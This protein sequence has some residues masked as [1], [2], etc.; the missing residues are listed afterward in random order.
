MDNKVKYNCIETLKKPGSPVVIVSLA[1]EA[2]AVA[3]A[4]RDAGIVVT[5]FCD[6]EKRKS[7]KLFCGLE[8]IHTPA[9]PKHFPKARFIIAY[10]NI[11]DCVEQLSAMGYDEFYSSLELLENY[12]V[13]KH[14]HST[15]QSYMATKISVS[16]RSHELYFDDSK[17]YLRS[18]DIV[19][20]TKC[21]M[22]CESCNNLMQY[23]VAAKN[24]DHEILSAVEILNENVGDISEF[25]V[26]G[27]EPFMNKGWA[28]IVNGII[29]KDS[30]REVFVYTNGTI[31]PKDDQLKSIHGKKV[32]FYITDYGKLSRN[33]NKLTENLTKHGI[34]Y[35]RIP[36]D[37][38]VDCSRIRHHKRTVSQ[39][40]QVF[41]ECCAK[42][43]Y[44]LLSGRLYTCPFIANAAELKAIPDNR[45]DY[46]DLFSKNDN[47]KQKIRRL[48]KM[49][50]YFPAC[51]FCDG[52]P[53]DPTTALEYAGK[54]LIKAGQQTS[55]R[56]PYKEYK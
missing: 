21:S 20:T 43:L 34:S 19:I 12:D 49:E 52:R 33:I 48:V 41:K 6:N 39:I 28:D 1:E 15:S 32:N 35:Y 25:R 45:D 47:L 26:I 40:K 56:L 5:V 24:T 22:K 16:K 29:E 42:K 13:N 36:A 53:K 54:G 23:Y 46:V 31:A 38:W 27:G 10:H 50:N 7:Q 14:T 11:N 17:T 51:D 18:L 9:L 37:N 30:N 44:T 4:C 2:E 8:V 3:N 55:Q